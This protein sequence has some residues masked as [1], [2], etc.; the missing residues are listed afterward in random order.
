MKRG[1]KTKYSAPKYSRK[2]DTPMAVIKAAMR[3]ASRRGL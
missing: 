1:E 2:K 3:A